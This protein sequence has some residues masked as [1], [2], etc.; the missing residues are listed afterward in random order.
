MTYQEYLELKAK[1]AGK[2]KEGEALLAKKDFDGHKAL[3]GEV[4]KMNQELDAAEAQLAEE[5]R[6]AEDDEGMKLRSKAFQ[7]KNEE[8]AKGAA[9]DE[10]RRS[11]EYATAFAKALR[12]GVKVNKVWGME[13]YEPL[14]KALTE[15]GGS[16]EGADGGFLVPQDFDNMI[17]E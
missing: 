10:I 17:H 15:T 16:P 1:R 13:G 3:M 8:K 11:N 6:F 9:I 12:N 14:A 2:L 5:G 7:A 4:S